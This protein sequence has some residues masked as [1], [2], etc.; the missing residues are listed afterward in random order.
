[1]SLPVVLT[2]MAQSE[3]DDAGDWYEQRRSGLQAAFLEAIQRVLDRISDRPE[4]FPIVRRDTREGLVAGYPYCV[5][6]RVESDRVVVVSIFHTSRD[7]A[8]RQRRN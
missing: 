5:Y 1:M 7:P 4:M 8:I 6:Y 3:M 2:P